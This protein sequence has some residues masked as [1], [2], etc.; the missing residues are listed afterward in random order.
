MGFG[1]VFI[2]YLFMYSFPYKGIDVLPDIIGFIIAYIGVRNLSDYGCGWDN[3][4]RYFWI[5]LP[6]SGVTLATQVLKLTVPNL[7]IYDIWSYF[8][9]A[10]LLVYNVMLLVAVYHIADDTEVLSIKA[11][12][13]RNL[14]LGIIYYAIMLLVNIPLPAVQ[15]LN[16]YIST[17]IPLGLVLFLFGYIW[18]FLNLAII[19]SCYM[20]ICQLVDEDMPYTEKKLFKKK[21]EEDTQ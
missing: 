21:K 17:K 4:K 14:V 12:A 20:W 9:T 7:S 6:A 19:F 11:K 18:Q 16:A 13:Q 5:L 3:L 15:A 2:G 10:L 8:Y 1:Y